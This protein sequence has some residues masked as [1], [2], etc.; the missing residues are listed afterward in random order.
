MAGHIATDWGLHFPASFAAGYG[1]VTTEDQSH[2]G[3][4]ITYSSI[5]VSPSPQMLEDRSSN[6]IAESP[7]SSPGLFHVCLFKVTL[8]LAV[9]AIA[10]H[11]PASLTFHICCGPQKALRRSGVHL[12][13]ALTRHGNEVVLTCASIQFLPS[14]S[15]AISQASRVL[16]EVKG[17]S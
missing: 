3:L 17:C 9:F 13:G 12:C 8:V 1:H 15:R 11:L 14:A 16:D 4:L 5:P 6:H 10:Y 7:P 2:V